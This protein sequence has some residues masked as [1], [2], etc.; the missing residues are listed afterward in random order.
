[1]KVSII[2]VT[3]NSAKTL[4]DTIQSVLDQTYTDIE[5]LIIDGAS[6]DGTI[7][8]IKRFEPLFNARMRWMSEK[9]HGIYD[10]MNKGIAMATGDVIGILNSDDYYT[11]NDVIERMA[12]EFN[13]PELDAVYGDI[14]FIRDG[15]PN[16]C[17]R[18]YSS[19]HFHPK[20]LR[21]GMMPAHPS[22]YCRNAVYKKVGNYKT[23]YKI[24]ADYDMMVR[25]FWVHHINARHLQMDFVTMRTGGAST[26][27]IHSRLALIKEDVRACRENGLYTNILMISMKFFYKIFEFK[28]F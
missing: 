8:V 27:D 12:S 20:W 3:Y 15:E 18:Y 24:G 19:K 7:E 4:A 25:M 16:K 23:D 21:F 17:V 1:M 11:S 13:D 22:F 26:R 2:T 5:Y 14:H 9:D 28:F 10:A 6:L